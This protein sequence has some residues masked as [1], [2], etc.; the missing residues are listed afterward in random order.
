M[1]HWYPSGSADAPLAH[2][3]RLIVHRGA[4][5]APGRHRLLHR[6]VGVGN[7]EAQADGSAS[8]RRRRAPSTPRQKEPCPWHA[9]CR[10]H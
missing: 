8:E 7:N 9:L 6:S 2:A 3:V 10:R 1:S 5:T 4:L